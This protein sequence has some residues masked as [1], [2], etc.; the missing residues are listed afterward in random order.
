[1]IAIQ[2]SADHG[3]SDL[4]A[5]RHIV[6]NNTIIRPGYTFDKPCLIHGD[7]PHWSALLRDSS[8]IENTHNIAR[9]PGENPG[10]FFFGE[11]QQGARKLA[12]RI[13]LTG[14]VTFQPFRFMSKRLFPPAPGKPSLNV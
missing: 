13:V 4:R 5:G 11:K 7:Q 2:P 1:M 9:G 14:M 3:G 8:L 12:P 6:R 10:L